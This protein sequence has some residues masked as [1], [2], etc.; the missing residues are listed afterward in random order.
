M[1][2]YGSNQGELPFVVGK[3][4]KAKLLYDIREQLQVSKFA[5]KCDLSKHSGDTVEK[6]RLMTPDPVTTEMVGAN[7]GV[8]TEQEY[9]SLT[10][11][12]KRYGSWV[13]THKHIVDT[14]DHPILQGALETVQMQSSRS[15]ETL[16]VDIIQNGTSAFYA[17][18]TSRVEV[19][20]YLRAGLLDV[21]QRYLE[22]SEAPTITK[23]FDSTSNWGEQALDACYITFCPHELTNDFRA[24]LGFTRVEDYSSRIK[25]MLNEIGTYN[26]QRVIATGFFKGRLGAGATL[27]GDD[28]TNIMNTGNK[29]DVFSVVTF[30]KGAFAFGG[31]Q[32][33]NAMNINVHKP[34]VSDTDK[35]GKKGH[36]AWDCYFGGLIEQQKFI[37]RIECV[38]KTDSALA[39]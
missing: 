32:G 37:S 29:A 31:L 38:A 36:V 12:M 16:S 17:T 26:R 8:M 30:G 11:K 23:M 5:E 18:G 6:T 19:K 15:V 28:L 39:V 14:N 4:V 24:M 22:R 20:D 9:E 1:A 3:D 7:D 21:Q 25:P 2:T 33:E 27:S 10:F 35:H 13:P 34:T